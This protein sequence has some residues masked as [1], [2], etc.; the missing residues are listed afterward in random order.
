[1]GTFSF[2][3]AFFLDFF[4]AP[5]AAGGLRFFAVS[6]ASLKYAS[7]SEAENPST[8]VSSATTN[9]SDSLFTRADRNANNFPSALK[10][11]A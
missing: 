1:M 3:S 11:G 2:A 9:T 10:R 5:G 7:C 4:L 6:P 8:D